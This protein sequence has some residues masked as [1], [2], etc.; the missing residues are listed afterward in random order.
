MES[1]RQTITV[2]RINQSP[3]EIP[4][5]TVIFV[6]RSRVV[7]GVCSLK[8]FYRYELH[9]QG[10]VSPYSNRDLAIGG[11]VHEGLDLLLQGG[12]L[13]KALEVAVKYFYDQ[14]FADSLLLEQRERLNLD[15]AHLVQAFVF[16]FDHLY[17]NDIFSQYKVLA[18][19]E[20]I[21]WL[22]GEMREPIYDPNTGTH[23][24][25]IVVMS[26]PDGVWQHLQTENYWH[27]SHKTT[28]VY[29]DLTIQG[30]EVDE[31][32][33]LE[34][35]AIW[36]KYGKP[37]EGSYYNYFLKGKRYWDKSY[38]TERLVNGIIRPYL[39]R[40]AVTGGEILPDM[41]SYVGEW[42]ELEE[43]N[44]M[45]VTHKVRKGFE[46]VS[47]YDE[48][49]YGTYLEWVRDEL[50]PRKKNYLSELV[51]GLIPEYFKPDLALEDMGA[52]MQDEEAWARKMSIIGRNDVNS[53]TMRELRRRK[54]HC[55]SFGR[56]CTYHPICWRG[57]SV[58]QLVDDGKLIPRP[59]NHLQEAD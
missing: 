23:R 55:L 26:R 42:T 43:G 38:G 49:D 59:I 25:K 15:D 50:V 44:P 5:D 12:T 52:L 46:R 34:C 29:T 22:L 45:P 33:F 36:A 11:A 48:M 4:R 21:N 10:Y 24:D 13:A 56:V 6:D 27:V 9:G 37:P 18:I 17:L 39:N 57:R 32:R 41:I 14:P 3:I 30:L 20:E 58:E 2:H 16:A 7:D 19:E 47:I 8:R 35:M 54:S 40:L 53:Y 1:E 28:G 51:V 31:Q